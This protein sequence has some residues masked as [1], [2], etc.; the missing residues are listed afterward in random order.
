MELYIELSCLGWSFFLLS[1]SQNNL[2]IRQ[3]DNFQNLVDI[4][5]STGH[6]LSFQFFQSKSW[7][8][9]MEQRG[10]YHDMPNCTGKVEFEAPSPL[11]GKQMN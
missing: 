11:D 2:N 3:N 4:V 10:S 6:F 9:S 8:S 7:C 5:F 1:I